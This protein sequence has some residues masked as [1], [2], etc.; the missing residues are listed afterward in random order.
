MGIAGHESDTSDEVEY[1][2]S[3]AINVRDNLEIEGGG[4]WSVCNT[5]ID[6]AERNLRQL[7]YQDRYWW[8]IETAI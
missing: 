5:N 7:P 2:E 1:A 3:K 6:V 8:R 4:T